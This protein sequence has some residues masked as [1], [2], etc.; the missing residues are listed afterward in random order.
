MLVCVRWS[1]A[2]ALSL[3]TFEEMMAWR[4]V[5]VDHATVHRWSLKRLPVLATVF[6][7]RKLAVGV[8][9]PVDETDVLVGGHGNH[10]YRALDKLGQAVDFLPTA[11]RGVAAARR[12]FERAIDLHDVPTCI[13]IDKGGANTV[14]VRGLV[15]DSGTTVEL[16][17]SE[18]LNNI[19]RQGHRAIK[20]R[21]RSMMG[22]KSFSAAARIIAGI[23]TMHRVK[24]GLMRCPAGEHLPAAQHFYSLAMQS[25]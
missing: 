14:A 1:A 18:C 25:S 10:L 3:R 16:R 19:A 15:T 7:R 4:G 22:F 12:L 6:R 24:K 2:K 17:Q 11:R 20:R 5:L 13:T 9:W 8:S 21:T 23:E